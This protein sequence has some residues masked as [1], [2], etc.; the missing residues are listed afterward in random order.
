MQ[1][2]IELAYQDFA[3]AIIKK[4]VDDYRKAL[5]GVSYGKK[6]PTKVIQEVEKFFRSKYFEALTDVDGE[7]LISKLKQEH[8][9]NERKKNESHINAI[10]T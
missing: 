7:F 8:K 1:N 6:S 5:D 10:H 4:A 9:E 3:N 2:P